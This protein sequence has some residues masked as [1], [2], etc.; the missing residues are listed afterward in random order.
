MIQTSYQHVASTKEYKI[1][2]TLTEEDDG[3]DYEWNVFVSEITQ[4][5]PYEDNTYEV[6]IPLEV[7][8]YI[9]KDDIDLPF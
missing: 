7:K 8:D 5:Y 1:P 3:I 9:D 6:Q 2:I 4:Y